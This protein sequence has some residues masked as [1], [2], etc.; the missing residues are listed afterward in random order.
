MHEATMSI[1]YRSLYADLST[2][3]DVDVELWCNN[4]WD[5][6]FLRG[7]D[8]TNALEVLAAELGVYDAIVDG[9]DVLAFTST[10]L[11]EHGDDFVEAHLERNDCRTIPPLS[12][13][14][15]RIHLRIVAS[16]FEHL[17]RLF[18]EL[19]ERFAVSVVSKRELETAGYELLVPRVAGVDLTDRQE[20]ALVA[21]FEGGYYDI[22][23]RTRTADLADE[24]GV[25]RRTFEYHLRRAE[26]RLVARFLENFRS[27]DR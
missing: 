13:H 18:E 10:C 4:R 2:E 20:T 21:A 1:E 7:P 24:I 27:V 12:Y 23:R 17:S 19:A 9:T 26:N 3:Y 5:I 22:P 8:S 25:D 15:G 6:I 14:D 11:R 16:E